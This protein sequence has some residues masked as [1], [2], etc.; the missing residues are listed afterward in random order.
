MLLTSAGNQRLGV[1]RQLGF[2]L[3]FMRRARQDACAMNSQNGFQQRGNA[4]TSHEV[5]RAA[6]DAKR[7]C[8][9]RSL[10]RLSIELADKHDHWGD[11]AVR[12]QLHLPGNELER[13]E[14]SVAQS[15]S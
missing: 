2:L 5:A 12:M 10:G 3:R 13:D 1:L 9:Q 7:E 6:Q 14:V 15:E 4:T 8:C 11:E